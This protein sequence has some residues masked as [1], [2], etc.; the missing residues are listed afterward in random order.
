MLSVGCRIKRFDLSKYRACDTAVYRS[1]ERVLP[2]IAFHPSVFHADDTGRKLK[3]SMSSVSN[4]EIAPIIYIV[5]KLF[6]FLF[7]E[8]SVSH[9]ARFSFVKYVVIDPRIQY[10]R[11]LIGNLPH[12][13]L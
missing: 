9:R 4:V 1:I 11:H 5:H 12:S 6:R 7:L 3:A 13:N 2:S 8:L 10:V